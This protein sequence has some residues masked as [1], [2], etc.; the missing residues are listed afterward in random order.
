MIVGSQRNPEQDLCFKFS[1]KSWARFMFKVFKE[2]LRKFTCNLSLE[3]KPKEGLLLWLYL[4]S[5]Y[6]VLF[7]FRNSD[8]LVSGILHQLGTVFYRSVLNN[9]IIVRKVSFANNLNLLYQIGIAVFT[10]WLKKV[11]YNPQL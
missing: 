4:Q 10:M 7:L 9:A 11:F 1:K 6:I 3:S 8:I 5:I 2:I